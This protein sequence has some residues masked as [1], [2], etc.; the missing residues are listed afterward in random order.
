MAKSVRGRGSQL[1][2]SRE[3]QAGVVLVLDSQLYLSWMFQKYDHDY[4]LHHRAM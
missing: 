3:S 4:R 2:P 1:V